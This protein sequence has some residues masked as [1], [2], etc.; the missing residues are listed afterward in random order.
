MFY[1]EFKFSVPQESKNTLEE[2]DFQSQLTWAC[3]LTDRVQPWTSTHLGR[4]FSS[5]FIWGKPSW[6][7]RGTLCTLGTYP[8]A[9]RAQGT[10]EPCSPGAPFLGPGCHTPVPCS[11]SL[12]CP[13]GPPHPG[14]LSS[15]Y[16]GWRLSPT[17]VHLRS[18]WKTWQTQSDCCAFCNHLGDILEFQVLSLDI[19]C[20]FALY[21]CH[22]VTCESIQTVNN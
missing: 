16:P 3:E 20:P 12:P 14:S 7:F 10:T 6:D 17:W 21:H 18:S 13:Q 9:S 22:P 1:S 2:M 8:Q 5:P 11:L 19:F 4:F 15:L